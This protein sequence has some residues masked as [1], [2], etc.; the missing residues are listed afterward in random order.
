MQRVLMFSVNTVPADSQGKGTVFRLIRPEKGD[1]DI[2]NHFP[3]DHRIEKGS[4]HI[5]PD[6]LR[7]KINTPAL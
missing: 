6:I 4:I 3:V 2:R 5:R 7:P 1:M